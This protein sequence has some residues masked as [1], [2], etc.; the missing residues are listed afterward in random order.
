MTGLPKARWPGVRLLAVL[1]VVACAGWQW[2]SPSARRQDSTWQLSSAQPYD[3]GLFFCNYV[4]DGD[5]IVACKIDGD[6]VKEDWAIRVRLLG[7]NAPEDSHKVDPLGPEATAYVK[8]K[9]LNK[10]IELRWDK[11]RI[12]KYGRRLGYVYAGGELFNAQLVKEGYARVFNYPGDNATIARELLKAEHSARLE[13]RGIWKLASV[14]S[15]AE[16]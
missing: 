6:E 2:F 15:A 9:L 13:Q 16:E 1:L 4:L 3:E 12:D 11:R 14:S 10:E 5:T 8:E 7:I